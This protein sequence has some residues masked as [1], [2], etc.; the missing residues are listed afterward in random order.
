MKNITK[1]NYKIVSDIVFKHIGKNGTI[2]YYIGLDIVDKL[3]GNININKLIEL[4]NL[5]NDSI[6]R[7]TILHDYY[8]IKENDECFLPRL[9]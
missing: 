7:E 3:I 6:T 5:G 4:D 2:D 1:T 9:S 8:G